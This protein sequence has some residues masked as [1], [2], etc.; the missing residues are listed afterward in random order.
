M[1]SKFVNY[2]NRKY[3][4]QSF[5][6]S[7][8]RMV[9]PRTLFLFLIIS[10]LGSIL[11][12]FGNLFEGIIS[13]V[14]SGLVTAFGLVLND[15]EDAELDGLVGKHRN[16]IAAGELSRRSGYLIALMFLLL[17]LLTM[18]LLNFY[19][20]ILGLIVIFL[21]YSYSSG[22]RAKSKPVLDVLYHGLCLA[23]FAVMGYISQR[24]FNV[25]CLIFSAVIFFLSGVSE[26][27]QEIRDWE[28]DRKTIETTVT[29]LGRKCSL[30]LCLVFFSAVLALFATASFHGILPFEY[31][32]LSP[33][34]YFVVSPIVKAIGSTKYLNETM[35]IINNRV[36]ILVVILT[37]AYLLLKRG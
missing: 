17:S 9:R 6:K 11:A 1:Y 4:L 24:P 20:Q 25:S 34:T 32:L 22:I 37:A 36:P 10:P 16:P 2:I 13:M 29:K 28:S 33:L 21:F 15:V 27:L 19:N 7:F 23:I 30:I 12:S 26:I 8:V 3:K 18:P 14:F 5:L 35:R 31:L